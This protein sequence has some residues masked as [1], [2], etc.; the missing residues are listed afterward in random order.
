MPPPKPLVGIPTG[1]SVH[2]DYRTAQYTG[3]E[4]YIRA[5]ANGAGAVPV[6]IPAIG[7]SLDIAALL[8][9][10]DGVMLPGGGPNIEPHHYDGAPFPD[11]ELTDPARDALTL[12]L[13][14]ACLDLNIPVFGVCRGI[15]EINVAL[16]GSLHYRIH[17]LPGKQ[18]H[19]MNRDGSIEDRFAIR[20]NIALTK[21]GL[22]SSLVGADSTGVNS[23]HGQ[24]IDRLAS[25]LVAEAVSPDGIIE[26]VRADTEN[27][28]V[29][30]VQWHAEWNFQTHKLSHELLR[31][32]GEA[33][34]ERAAQRK[35]S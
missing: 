22:L 4:M 15:Q 16:G 1:T 10:L 19:R 26:A 32:F 13:V 31:A 18:D 9:N 23:L 7:E 29:V 34:R 20:H 17:E 21:G 11:D 3:G 12:P 27:V 2:K 33:T 30:G 5:V 24:G 25:G 35:D 6:L 14:R 28:F 8:Q